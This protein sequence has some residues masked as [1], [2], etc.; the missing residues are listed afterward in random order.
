MFNELNAAQLEA[1]TYPNGNLLVL[2][3]AGSGKT[4]VLVNRVAWLL[5]NGTNLDEIF[6]VTFTNKAARE[7]IA[8]L[9]NILNRRLQHLWIGTFHGLANRFLRQHYDRANLDANF[10]IIDSD[11]QLRLLKRI[12]RTLNLDPEKWLPKQSQN[13]INHQKENGIRVN[14]L[15]ITS[16][17]DETFREI[18]RAYEE[19]C[20]NG[21][22]VD[23]AELLLKTHELLTN[24][25][26]LG[27]FYQQK[28][29]HVLVDEFQ[30]TND[31]Q[32]RFIRNLATQNLMV[33]GD[34]DQSIYGW[35][36]AD[37]N[38]LK[39]LTK[40]FKQVKVLRLEQNYRSTK[41]ILAAA[42]AVISHNHNR[43]GKEL[44]TDA[45]AGEL[46]TVHRAINEIDEGN[47]IAVTIKKLLTQQVPLGDIAILYRS[48]AQSRILEEQL[49][50][51]QINYR[52]YGG[53]RF[54]ERSEIKDILAYLRLILNVNDDA[55]FERVINLPS[56]GLGEALLNQVRV[57]SREDQIS[58][59]EAMKSLACNRAGYLE[60]AEI[61]KDLNTQVD[62]LLLADL[63]AYLINRTKLLEYYS[64]PQLMDSLQN[65]KENLDELITAAQQFVETQETQDGRTVLQ[66][67]LASISLESDRVET[68]E[69]GEF[70]KMMTLHAAKGLEFPVVFITGLEEGLFPHAMSIRDGDIE[71]E[72]RLCYVGITRAKR[73]LYLVNAS[74]RQ[75]R[76]V[77]GINRVSRFLEE[78]PSDLIE[79]NHLFSKG[80][81][82]YLQENLE[83]DDL[84]NEEWKPNQKVCH[85]HFGE[86]TIVAVEGSG[87]FRLLKI[88]FNKY[89][90]KLLSP[91]YA[92]LK[93]L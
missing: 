32:Y 60:F 85:L 77:I 66:N 65:R 78:I 24:D 48:N 26:E 81:K 74:T 34:D 93:K 21:S 1:V 38:N 8:R 9:E 36:G 58:L 44:W 67:F 57:K 52:V 18:Y 4:R 13:Y 61:I 83:S 73:K 3:G 35:R 62:Q 20:R 40:D 87:E 46:L 41:N 71:E 29:R 59:S 6:A 56:R 86:G 76:G 11:D 5:A 72:R 39:R 75:N 25:V 47:F 45:E 68:E 17:Q 10:Q 88:R 80:P 50:R 54:F 84:G 2:A 33:V 42:N 70:V 31:M 91:K 19:V 89:G 7:M 79:Q 15:E 82:V 63:V 92:K 55:A 12:H 30:D 27:R 49:L 22:L 64:K 53:M 28:F 23:F 43:L 90:E 69:G 37:S 14:E 16:A 51:H